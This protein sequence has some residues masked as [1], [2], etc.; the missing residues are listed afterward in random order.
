MRVDRDRRPSRGLVPSPA[1]A[2]FAAGVAVFVALSALLVG[3]SA[4]TSTT[5]GTAS[6]AE[7]SADRTAFVGTV[8]TFTTDDR[9]TLSGRLFK[10]QNSDAAGV[11]LA[12]MYPAD[13]TS[14]WDYARTLAAE[15]YV[16]LTFD[17]RG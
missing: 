13:Q 17:F 12:H 15:G 10:G 14:W 3:C 1:V 4:G 9:G 5:G 8:V 2:S 16:A 11:V 7:T 6:G